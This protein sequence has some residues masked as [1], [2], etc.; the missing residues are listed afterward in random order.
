M[1]AVFIDLLKEICEE[2]GFDLFLYSG[3]WIA[4]VKNSSSSS[5]TIYGYNFSVNDAASAQ[6]CQ[7]KNATSA[8]LESAGVPVVKH[9][10][11]LNPTD[12]LV[13]RLIPVTGSLS[14]II[15]FA[16]EFNFRVVLKPVCGTGGNG[17]MRA[18]NCKEVEASAML[19]FQKY[20]G[21]VVCPFLY[22]LREIRVVVLNGQVRLVY[23][24]KRR[25]VIGDGVSPVSALILQQNEAS[26]KSVSRHVDGCSSYIPQE[27]EEVPI[28]WRHNLG[29]GATP[30]L[31]ADPDQRICD[32]AISTVNALGIRFCSVDIIETEAGHSSVLEVNAGVMMDSFLSSADSRYR[33]LAKSIYTD[34]ILSSLV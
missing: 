9:E 33:S 4:I 6:V 23:E 18:N 31:I 3:D 27:G 16:S 22:I 10:L 14:R 15:A 30:V 25:S 8:I 1:R 28:E 34:A 11:F 19:L 17:V 5:S 12:A 13:E 21:I 29:H 2:K 26:L 24:K 20:H 32:L 7:D